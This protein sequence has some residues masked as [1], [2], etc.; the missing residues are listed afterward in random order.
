MKLHRNGCTC[1]N[2]R[3]LI[4]ERVLEQNWSL[5]PAAAAA[6]V[7]ERC[8]RKWVR[9]VAAG[10][11]L[12]DRSSRPRRSPNATRRAPCARDRRAQAAADDGRRTAMSA[13]APAS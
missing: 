7:S 3:A 5:T 2:S 1:P 6:G 9:R 4:A 12:A 8:A 13:G 11:S 10:E